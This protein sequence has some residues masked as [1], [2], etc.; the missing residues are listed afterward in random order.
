[1]RAE[2]ITAIDSESGVRIKTAIGRGGY[3]KDI[4]V[5]GMNL[6]TMKWVFR[7]DGNYKS[8]PDN[9]YDP[10]AIPV[11]EGISYSDVIA[12]N[13]KQVARLHGIPNA[14]FTGICMSNVT[15][16]LA[17]KAK[18]HAWTCT[19][20]EGFSSGT[21]TPAPCSSFPDEGAGAKPCPFP[22]GRFTW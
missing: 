7:M 18:K 4:F 17:A 12:K 15:V 11:V 14:P 5:R 13:V 20:V 22:A 3:V 2:D 10:H 1:M 19:D 6:N 21:I 16:Q 9:K 8:H